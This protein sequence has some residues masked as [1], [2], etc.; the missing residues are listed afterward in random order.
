MEMLSPH[1]ARAASTPAK[2]LS[3]F[4][5]VSTYLKIIVQYGRVKTLESQEK[6]KMS[7]VKRIAKKIVKNILI[8]ESRQESRQESSQE[9]SR[10]GS[11][12]KIV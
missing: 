8:E 12:V 2:I 7:R 9:E 5:E 4:S 1:L 6:R 10:V 11:K 3:I